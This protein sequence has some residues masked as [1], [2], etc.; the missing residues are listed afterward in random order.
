[1]MDDALEVIQTTLQQSDWLRPDQDLAFTKS[2]DSQVGPKTA[3]IWV[4]GLDQQ[5]RIRLQGEYW[6]EG[7]NILE[8]SME[9]IDTANS[10]IE[11]IRGLVEGFLR[12]QER[13][14]AQSYAVRLLRHAAP[15]HNG[16]ASHEVN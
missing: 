1:M 3:V 16:V 4:H 6:S 9:V 13:K 14:I 15:S 5:Q 7:R 8:P 11:E 10:S 2:F 12:V